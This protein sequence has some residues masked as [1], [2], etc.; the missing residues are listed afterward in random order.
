MAPPAQSYATDAGSPCGP[1][2]PPSK[3]PLTLAWGV[4]AVATLGVAATSVTAPGAALFVAPARTGTAAPPAFA[5]RAPA[6]RPRRPAVAMRAGPRSKAAGKPVVEAAPRTTSFGAPAWATLGLL[7]LGGALLSLKALLPRAPARRARPLGPCDIDAVPGPGPWDPLGLLT[8]GAGLR[9]AALE[10]EHGRLAMLASLG[11][12][13]P[14]AYDTIRAAQVVD[15]RDDSVG[16]PLAGLW[17]RAVGWAPLLLLLGGG[18][19]PR[20]E[21]VEACSHR[22]APSKCRVPS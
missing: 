19:Y 3:G 21:G 11:A 9:S 17:R 16:S 1:P 6:L 2:P 20:D 12:T 14:P 15:P 10:R 8:P 5:T 4:L 22:S 13:A 18:G 7:T